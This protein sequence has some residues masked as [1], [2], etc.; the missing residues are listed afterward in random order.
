MKITEEIWNKVSKEIEKEVDTNIDYYYQ[1]I[2]KKIFGEEVF[3]LYSTP[4]YTP[5]DFEVS[6][7]GLHQVSEFIMKTLP[8]EFGLT[9]GFSIIVSKRPTSDLRKKTQDNLS[10]IFEQKNMLISS[11]YRPLE[12]QPT[13]LFGENFVVFLK[14]G[15]EVYIDEII[16][17]SSAAREV[18]RLV[19]RFREFFYTKVQRKSNNSF[20]L[21]TLEIRGPKLSSVTHKVN[22]ED[23]IDLSTDFPSDLPH[24]QVQEFIESDK[25][26]IAI[27]H[28]Q[29]GCGKSSYIKYLMKTNPSE[30]F[31]VISTDLVLRNPE[32][33]RD[34]MINNGRSRIYILEDCENLLRSRNSGNE[35]GTV[36][37]DILNF[38][39]GI[40]GSLTKTKYILTFNSSLT[41]IDGALQRRGRLKIKYEFGPLCGDDLRRASE[42]LGIELTP[43]DISNGLTLADLYNYSSP[44]YTKEKRKIGF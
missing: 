39:D 33:V 25:S 21:E 16:Y 42:K 22:L 23:D 13:V 35:L 12:I 44:K 17:T 5:V 28:G 31:T 38:A 1:N 18:F 20:T 27:F 41:K 34:Y 26:G 2:C 19:T 40:L 37:S 3:V 10:G 43:E 24:S 36:L 7:E 8:D 15:E 6:E 11:C 4:G 30:R 32:K 29:P 14:V 9:P